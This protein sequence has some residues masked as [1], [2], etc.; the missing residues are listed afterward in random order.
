MSD[1]DS[2]GSH[3]R[4]SKAS[5]SAGGRVAQVRKQFE[6][7]SALPSPSAKT[8]VSA[9][10]V[11][12]AKSAL[13]TA[14]R[15]RKA[16]QQ[17]LAATAAVSPDA[18]GC[19]PAAPPA[20]PPATSWRDVLMGNSPD[21]RHTILALVAEGLRLLALQRRHHHLHHH[22]YLMLLDQRPQQRSV[23][24]LEICSSMRLTNSYRGA[25]VAADGQSSLSK[26]QC[27]ASK[28]LGNIY[29]CTHTN[30][31]ALLSGRRSCLGAWH[32]D[33]ACPF[34]RTAALTPGFHAQDIVVLKDPSCKD[35][36]LS[37]LQ[38]Q[39]QI[40]QAPTEVELM[41]VHLSALEHYGVQ[42]S[43]VLKCVKAA[44]RVIVVF[45]ACRRHEP[46]AGCLMDVYSMGNALVV[47]SCAPGSLAFDGFLD[48]QGYL[49]HLIED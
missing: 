1:A 25:V 41:L 5:R 37:L 30:S 31:P 33:L 2:A 27:Q 38:M 35:L 44:N 4:A 7:A 19:T 14:G 6:A 34:A 48:G 13:K 20:K 24:C 15:K 3:S 12:A 39:S 32:A 16:S 28:Q 10:Q 45:D 26:E 21:D 42:V 22:Q 17:R 49:T 18:S 11:P 40:S 8:T 47:Y 23:P 36:K 9:P 46:R 29:T 43:F